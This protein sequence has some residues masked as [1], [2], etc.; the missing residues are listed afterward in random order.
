L[1][2]GRKSVKLWA[3]NLRMGTIPAYAGIDAGYLIS[4]H[5][6][7]QS[8]MASSG[9]RMKRRIGDAEQCDDMPVVVVK[10]V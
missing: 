5:M 6:R 8:M 7:G 1:T 9:R 10:K 3:R 2:T 4:R